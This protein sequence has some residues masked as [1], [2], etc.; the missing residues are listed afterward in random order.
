[1]NKVFYIFLKKLLLLFLLLLL[2]L[3]LSFSTE[4]SKTQSEKPRYKRI[5][6]PN[7][8]DVISVVE[9]TGCVTESPREDCKLVVGPV[10][11]P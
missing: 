8:S 11:H 2:L 6:R 7:H 10:P 5:F 1:M 3:L 9:V 4:N